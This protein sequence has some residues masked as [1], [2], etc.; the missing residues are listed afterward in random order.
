MNDRR[1]ASGAG[2]TPAEPAGVD[3]TVDRGARS[4]V[5][6]SLGLF[7]PI[8]EVGFEYTQRLASFLELGVAAGGGYGGPQVAVMPRL[9]AGTGAMSLSLGA[10]L[11]GG[12][13]REPELI[14]WGDHDTERAAV[15][16]WANLEGGVQGTWRSG[17]LLR[18]YGGVGRI[19]WSGDCRGGDDWCDALPGSVLPY[20]GIA[21]GHTL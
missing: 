4:R 9:R 15:A 3:E 16:I 17:A 21:I 5:S 6:L 11:S 1:D 13:Y 12:P 18:V 7:T 19:M 14:V 8:G 2:R 20:V 10:G